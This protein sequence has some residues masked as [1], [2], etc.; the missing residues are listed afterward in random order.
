MGRMGK[1]V[2]GS[3]TGMGL[4]SE[5]WGW[6]IKS[7]S[8]PALAK[9]KSHRRYCFQG[10]AFYLKRRNIKHRAFRAPEGS[11]EQWA[12]R[13]K[14][15][16]AAWSWGRGYKVLGVGAAW[17]WVG[18]LQGGGW[19]AGVQAWE[20]GCMALGAGLHG[21]G[22]DGGCS[23]QLRGGVTSEQTGSDP[24]LLSGPQAQPTWPVRA[25]SSPRPSDTPQLGGRDSAGPTL[26]GTLSAGRSDTSPLGTAP[27]PRTMPWRFPFIPL[28]LLSP[29]AA[30]L[31]PPSLPCPCWP[32]TALSIAS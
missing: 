15:G 23:V 21:P 31:S 24:G 2:L 13:R 16:G 12:A 9:G 30:P 6:G 4:P 17:P 8:H 14:G 1:G 29:L 20:W 11:W 5:G 28:G 25:D 7:S 22:V 32:F 26:L 10:K 19:G 27:P 3:A 18:G